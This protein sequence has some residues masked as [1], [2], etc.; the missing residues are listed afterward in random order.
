MIFTSA[1]GQELL[2]AVDIKMNTTTAYHP[3]TDGQTEREN[4]CLERCLRCMAFDNPKKWRKWLS[5]AEWWYNTGYHTSLGMTPFQALYGY[6][7]PQVTE[8]ITPDSISDEAKGFMQRRQHS[9][10]IIEDNLLKSQDIMKNMQTE[11]GRRGSSMRETWSTSR[12]SPTGTHP[13][14]CIPSFMDHSWC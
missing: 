13:S 9:T 12:Y 11:E 4:Q 3:E 14:D 1:L 2:Q 10:Q 5:L 8:V 6:L 7:P